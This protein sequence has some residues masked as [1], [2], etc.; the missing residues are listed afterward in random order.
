MQ[1]ITFYQGVAARWAVCAVRQLQ[2]LL[3]LKRNP[4]LRDTWEPDRQVLSDIALIS[5]YLT[6][7]RLA[8][9]GGAL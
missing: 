3:S 2:M 5:S 7:V 6:M 1:P 8:R 9:H 4:W